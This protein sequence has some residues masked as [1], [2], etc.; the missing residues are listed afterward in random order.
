MT[1]L[2]EARKHFSWDHYASQTTGCQIDEVG[3]KY[4][5]CKNKAIDK[6]SNGLCAGRN[7]GIHAVIESAGCCKTG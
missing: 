7:N 2:E 3:E 4:A 5:K 1:P 6:Q